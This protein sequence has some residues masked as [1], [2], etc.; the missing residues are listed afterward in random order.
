KELFQYIFEQRKEWHL[1]VL[2][3]LMPGSPTVEALKLIR[4][5]RELAYEEQ[6]SGICPV[7]TLPGN[8]EQFMT[9]LGSR[10]RRN[11]RNYQRRLKNKH[12]IEFVTAHSD[13]GMVQSLFGLHQKRRQHLKAYTTFQHR[14]FREFLNAVAERFHE[15][16]YNRFY[17]FRQNDNIIALFYF[18]EFKNELYLYQGGFDNSRL[19]SNISLMLALFDMSVQDAIDRG[20]RKIHF[21][22]GDTDFKRAFTQKKI[23]TKQLVIGNR[24][25]LNLYLTVN[26]FKSKSR[27]SLK[28]I[29]PIS[30]WQR[31][32][33]L[34][35]RIT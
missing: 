29:V 18:F 6:C 2:S 24:L 10:T 22:D 20:V 35:K 34:L 33:R 21:L 32:K 30:V 31:L 27:Q 3:N 23:L 16:G 19:P 17:A 13:H 14:E 25:I 15:T 7:L 11:I 8:H 26:C 28:Q 1:I 4:E 9:G 5:V 12:R